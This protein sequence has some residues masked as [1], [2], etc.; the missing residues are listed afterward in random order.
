MAK[1]FLVVAFVLVA[2][3]IAYLALSDIP[4][5]TKTV[6]KPISTERFFQK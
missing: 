4:A 2:S 3:G 6:E 5:P 1:I